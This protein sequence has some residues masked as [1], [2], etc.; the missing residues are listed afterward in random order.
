MSVYNVLYVKSSTFVGGILT[1]G[2]T[3]SST[4]V[5]GDIN[6]TPNGTGGVVLSGYVQLGDMAAPTNPAAGEGR[7]YKKTGNDGVF[8]KPDATG[9][10]IDLTT[11]PQYNRVAVTNAESPYA[12]LPADEIVGVDTTTAAVTVTLPQI[13]AIGGGNNYRKY[14]IVDEGG[15]ATVNNITVATTGGN[16]INKN[17]SPMIMAVGH[18]SITLYSDGASNWVI[19]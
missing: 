6:I 13:S 14:Y 16:T 4:Q 15:N 7:L 1:S 11:A 2:N 12:V 3:I 17:A 9:L 5:N 19:L 10:E 18:M 8:W